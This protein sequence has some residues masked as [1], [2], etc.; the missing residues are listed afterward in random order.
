MLSKRIYSIRSLN[1]NPQILVCQN[2]TQQPRQII[3]NNEL[4][5]QLIRLNNILSAV[6]SSPFNL[7]WVVLQAVD[8]ALPEQKIILVDLYLRQQER[9]PQQSVLQN[10][11]VFKFQQIPK[12]VNYWDYFIFV[13]EDA[14]VWLS[15]ACY[16]GEGPGD[17]LDF[18]DGLGISYL[19]RQYFYYIVGDHLILDI[20][21]MLRKKPKCQ[22][23]LVAYLKALRLNRLQKNWQDH[24]LLNQTLAMVF[25]QIEP[26]WSFAKTRYPDPTWE[27]GNNFQALPPYM[28]T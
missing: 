27:Y 6:E 12:G 24:M 2:I 20:R 21:W 22:Y 25:I 9:D 1:L 18:F 4:Q 10:V 3:L 26:L 5:L 19:L 23:R 8:H 15:P 7:G 28:E 14:V 11:G 16:D 13:L 17:F